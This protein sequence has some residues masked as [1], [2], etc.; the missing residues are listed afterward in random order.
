[1]F[2]NAIQ[3]VFLFTNE[4]VF[5]PYSEISNDTFAHMLVLYFRLQNQNLWKLSLS[6]ATNSHRV[7]SC[8]KIEPEK[9]A[10]EAK[11]CVCVR[12]RWIQ[13]VAGGVVASRRCRGR[14]RVVAADVDGRR[15]GRWRASLAVLAVAAATAAAT[16]S[17]AAS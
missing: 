12:E 2:K 3:D 10:R 7:L 5:G 16:A 1:M 17:C 9:K 13:T 6:S 15:R 8:W 14:R 11:M 4:Y